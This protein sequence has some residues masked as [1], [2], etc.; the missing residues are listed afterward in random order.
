MVPAKLSPAPSHDTP[1]RRTTANERVLD[2][3]TPA[4][5]AHIAATMDAER[6]IARER[7]QIIQNA[8]S[9]L[10]SLAEREHRVLR[11][12]RKYW[13][14]AATSTVETGIGNA[15]TEIVRIARTRF[16]TWVYQQDRDAKAAP[17]T[18]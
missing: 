17:E 16:K 13:E 12:G 11:N 6:A 8:A 3:T 15:G 14:Q 1:R 4:Q 9:A 2:M 5:M 7:E 10:S 18:E